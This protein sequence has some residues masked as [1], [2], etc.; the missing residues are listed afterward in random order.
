LHGIWSDGENAWGELKKFLGANNKYSYKKYEMLTPNYPPDKHFKDNRHHIPTFISTLKQ[1]CAQNRTS[2]G[3]VDIVAHSMG[4]ILTRLYMQNGVGGPKYLNDIHKLVTVNTPH[5]G[6]PWANIVGDKDKFFK[7]FMNWQFDKNPYNGALDDLSIGEA[8]ID[9]LLNGPDLNKNKVPSHVIYTVD[10]IP[11]WAEFANER[12]IKFTT[13]PIRLKSK[14]Y[15]NIQGA[16]GM[17]NPYALAAKGGLFGLKYYLFRKI[18]CPYD[19]GL[20]DCLRKVFGSESDLIVSDISQRGGMTNAATFIPSLNHLNVCSA[21]PTMQRIQ[22]LF[23]AKSF[24]NDFSRNGFNPA[25]LRF[26]PILGT[27]NARNATDSIR[28]VDPGYGQAFNRGDS[29]R[30]TVR[31]SSGINRMMIAIGYENGL[32]AFALEGNDSVFRFKVPDDVLSKLY[33]KVFAVDNADNEHT[34]SSFITIGA[35]PNLLL[36][37]IKIVHPQKDDMKIAL[38]DSTRITTMG[39]FSD[40]IARDITRETLVSYTRLTNTVSVPLEGNVKGLIVGF[41][42]LKATYLGKTDSVDIEVIP[43]V[44]VDT[45]GNVVLPVRFAKVAAKYQGTHVL[46]TWQTSMEQNNSYFEVEHSA[47]AVNF[48][49]AGRVAATNVANGSSYSFAHNN[50]ITGNNYYRIKQVDLD[51]KFSHSLIVIA[52]API[53]SSIAIYPNPVDDILTLDFSKAIGHKARTVKVLNNLGQVLLQQT[54]A[55]NAVKTSLVL[56]GLQPGIYNIEILAA[57][58]TRIKTEKIIKNR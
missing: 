20:Q 43:P 7:W 24:E 25:K 2:V 36:D 56:A 58:N 51:N 27:Q 13:S 11:A 12:I 4:G 26:D 46:V 50:F 17:F 49:N 40:G 54:I 21:E 18:P 32:D 5:S 42:E 45:V 29:V 19:S 23:R 33:F 1:Y 57:D 28:I 52:N 9:S 16:A 48:I 38:G 22:E 53:Q 30:V 6:S 35:D 44:P 39:Y 41:D 10:T 34:D 8:A 55:S 3:K 37:S 47:D 31:A 14:P 15:L